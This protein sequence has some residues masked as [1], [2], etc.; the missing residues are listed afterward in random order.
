MKAL[1]Y[2]KYNMTF[3][4][5]LFWVYSGAE[6]F[7]NTGI[8]PNDLTRTITFTPEWDENGEASF[9]VMWGMPTA[10]KNNSANVTKYNITLKIHKHTFDRKVVD[11]KYLASGATCTEPAKYYVSCE[12]GE[13]GTE[14]FEYGE[15]LGHDYSGKW[16]Y[17]RNE[18]WKKCTRCGEIADS[19]DHDFTDWSFEYKSTTDEYRDCKVCGYHEKATI[20]KI[21]ENTTVKPAEENP[22]T[23]AEVFG[24]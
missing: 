10:E 1:H 6:K 16:I 9:Q 11:E 22:N 20:I 4:K 17:N 13:K 7:K 18:H 14:A 15:S 5:A 23:G 19:H 12:C 2:G 3:R 21:G 8:L 24:E